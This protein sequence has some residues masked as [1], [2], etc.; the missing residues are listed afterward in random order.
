M[1]KILIAL[2]ILLG[3]SHASAQ[4]VTLTE[5]QVAVTFYVKEGTASPYQG[6]LQYT[7]TEY[8]KIK[9]ADV[10]A[11]ALAQHA[12]W[13]AATEAARNVVAKEPTKEEKAAEIDALR[14]EAQVLLR[15]IADEAVAAGVPFPSMVIPGEFAA[16]VEKK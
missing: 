14:D 5:A 15:K 4:T 9:I 7:F 12:A 10:R 13:K 8:P 11:A 16:P 3:V 1:K 6:R 2:A